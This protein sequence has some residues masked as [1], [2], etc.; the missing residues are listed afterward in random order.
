MGKSSPE[1][2]EASPICGRA[3]LRG[4]LLHYSPTA[5]LASRSIADRSAHRPQKPE[6]A[7]KIIRGHMSVMKPVREYVPIENG[8]SQKITPSETEHEVTPKS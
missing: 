8:K 2:R 3:L 7:E 5:S 1:K 6:T 4:C